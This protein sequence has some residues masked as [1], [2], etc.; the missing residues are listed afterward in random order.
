MKQKVWNGLFVIVVLLEV[1]AYQVNAAPV[2]GRYVGTLRHESMK[3]D[4]LAKIDFV[5]SREEGNTILLKAIL[6]LHF[7]DFKS[8][9]YVAYHFDNVRFNLLTQTFIFDQSDQ[10]ITLV[11]KQTA[12]NE[13][14]GELRSDYSGE[15]GQL[16]LRSDK[17]ANPTLPLIETLWG[18]YR[19]KCN[20]KVEGPSTDTIVQ[21]YT[22]RSSEGAGQVGDP[23][24]AYKINGFI[25]EY[26][27]DVC[28]SGGRECIRGN[29]KSGSYNFFENRLFLFNNYQNLSCTTE[30]KGLNC[31]GCEPL[32]RVSEETKGP[33]AFIPPS[34]PS[35]FGNTEPSDSTALTSDVSSLQGKY[36]GY[37]HH[38]F[39]DRYQTGSLSILTYQAPGETGAPATLRMSALGTLYFGDEKS[40]EAISYR[41]KER[42]Y[43]NPLVST[44]FVF[45]QEESGVDA[46]LQVTSLGKGV[47]KG[48]W[49]SRLFGRVG[50]FEFRK[51][52]AVKLPTGSKLMEPISAFYES[53]DWE[54]DLLVGL[55]S[56]AP[57]TDNAFAPLTFQG[58]TLLPNITPKILIT[59]GSYDF[60]TGRIGIEADG[61]SFLGERPSRRKLLLKKMNYGILTPLPPHSLMPFRIMNNFEGRTR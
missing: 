30:S 7:G 34:P 35:M 52:D 15:T 1:I 17:P 50:S 32:L 38:E 14:T 48:I 26:S 21:L 28:L 18:E 25:G 22:Y 43:P 12:P 19:G 47:V 51:E 60:Y 3:R 45:S 54:M 6:T 10:P 61:I 44:Q 27:A 4:Q 31:D 13:F 57:N 20:S 46:V 36:R 41:F 5:V 33:R 2:F 55:G 29:I 9:D 42:A 37:L 23:F 58:W 49:F 59:G 8:G 11:G 39:L 53:T 40:S 56:S 16:Y 24:R